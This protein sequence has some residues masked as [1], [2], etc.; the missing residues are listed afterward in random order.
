MSNMIRIRPYEAQD[1]K[2]VQKICIATS[3][4]PKILNKLLLTTFCNYY[5]EQE[6]EHCFVAVDGDTVV[7][8]ILATKDSANWAQVFSKKYLTG[9][10]N[11]IL[12]PFYTGTM[13]Q[14]LKFAKEYPAH[15]HTDI[16]P[17]YQRQGIGHKLMSAL[18]SHLQGEKVPGLMLS[19]AADNEKGKSFYLKYGFTILAQTPME[20]IM[21]YPVTQTGR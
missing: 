9:I 20:I 3:T 17:E 7:G 15:L 8:Y 11:K 16:L 6:P 21:G 18:V 10:V 2:S 13:E 14:P 5:I 19:V 4:M 12:K 1:Y